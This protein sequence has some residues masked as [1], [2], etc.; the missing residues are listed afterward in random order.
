MQFKISA[1]ANNKISI[2]YNTSILNNR[3]FSI[4]KRDMLILIL[5]CSS[6]Y[7]EIS[8]S[9]ADVPSFGRSMMPARPT[10]RYALETEQVYTIAKKKHR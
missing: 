9:G 5:K 4:L 10:S 7:C 8:T 3:Y 2:I 6:T 1:Y